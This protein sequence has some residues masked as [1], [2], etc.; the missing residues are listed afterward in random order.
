MNLP[1]IHRQK[2]TLA[3]KIFLSIAFGLLVVAWA[4]GMVWG[5]DLNY[6]VDTAVALSSPN[7][8]LTIISGSQATSLM[9]NAGNIVVAIP[10]GSNFTVRSPSRNL[11]VAGAPSDTIVATE[12]TNDRIKKVTITSQN[13]SN[14]SLTITPTDSQC[15]PT[16]SAAGASYFGTYSVP[17]QATT[18]IATTT[19]LTVTTTTQL[20]ATTAPA[21]ASVPGEIP[22]ESIPASGAYEKLLVRGMSDPDVLALQTLLKAL[23]PDIYPEGIVSGYF[24][25]LTNQ[26]VERFQLKYGVVKEGDSGL[27]IVGPKTRAALNSLLR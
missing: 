16:A 25:K 23:G 1:R 20:T 18:T 10:T 8:T 14:T 2:F 12:C 7:I 19:Q 6:N 21:S 13:T 17:T 3:E 15:S 27:G 24:G 5:A 11:T 4:P 9:V 26:A 22:K